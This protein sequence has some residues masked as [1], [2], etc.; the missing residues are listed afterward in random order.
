MGCP[1]DTSYPKPLATLSDFMFFVSS[2]PATERG[3]D[4]GPSDLF[5]AD[6]VF[7][8]RALPLGG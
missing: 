7:P 3:R 2:A 8:A 1:R 5:E 4:C 6:S